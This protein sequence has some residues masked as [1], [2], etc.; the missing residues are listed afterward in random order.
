MWLTAG[1]A[2]NSTDHT[3]VLRHQLGVTVSIWVW[4]YGRVD[5]GGGEKDKRNRQNRILNAG[6]VDLLIGLRVERSV[7]S[8]RWFKPDQ[9]FG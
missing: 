6:S 3:R 1:S 8:Q 7:R 2:E 5:S 4:D 9:T